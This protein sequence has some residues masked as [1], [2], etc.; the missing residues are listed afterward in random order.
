MINKRANDS[1]PQGWS[2]TQ[3]NSPDA[4]HRRT[5]L[6]PLE[7]RFCNGEM[8]IAR[9]KSYKQITLAEQFL[10]KITIMSILPTN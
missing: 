1:N 10:D 2:G 8:G 6:H 3:G 9:K 5:R 4:F 7:R